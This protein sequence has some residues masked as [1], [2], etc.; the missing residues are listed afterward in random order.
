M[1]FVDELMN[2][3]WI[4]ERYMWNCLKECPHFSDWLP[5]PVTHC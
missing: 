3:V 5:Y 1:V 2:E 4:G